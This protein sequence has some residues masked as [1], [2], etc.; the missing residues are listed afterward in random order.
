MLQQVYIIDI[1]A[2]HLVLQKVYLENILVNPQNFA[3]LFYKMYLIFEL[4]NKAFKW[5]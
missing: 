1:T 4:Q 2:A 5:F 3:G